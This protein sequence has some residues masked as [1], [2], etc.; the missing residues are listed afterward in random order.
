MR[1]SRVRLIALAELLRSGRI[2]AL[3]AAQEVETIVQREAAV[4]RR[5]VATLER[6]PRQVGTYASRSAID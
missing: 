2:D 1:S 5:V 3:R 4:V 6:A